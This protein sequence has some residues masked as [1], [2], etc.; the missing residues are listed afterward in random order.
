MTGV[1][2]IGECMIELKQAAGGFYSRGFGGDTLNTAVYLARLGAAVDYITAL[3]DDPLSDEM[4]AGWQAEG[5]GTAK[6]ARLEGKLPGLY[7]IATDD[8][9]ERRFYHWRESAAARNLLDLAETDGLLQSLAGYDLVYL[10][11]ISLSIYTESGRGRLF[12]AL[13][14]AR[15]RG[16]RIAFDTNFRARGWPDLDVARRVFREAFEA[17]DI[18]LASTEDLLPLYPSE[19]AERLLARIP[20]GEVILKLA[21]P[22]SIVR[23]RSTSRRIVAEPVTAPVVDTT[24]AGD[25]F[26]AAYLAARLVGAEPEEAARA[27]HHL[28]GVVVCHP[29][30]IIPRSAMPISSVSPRKASQ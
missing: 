16:T 28:A 23:V 17:A 6:V 27:G 11:A 24:A 13:S 25:S 3:G 15:Q 14:E 7:M 22:A 26:A 20:G 30:A 4:I 2:C 12:A 5:V 19:S 8:K 18:T 9:G 29:G 10:S 21:E 1:A